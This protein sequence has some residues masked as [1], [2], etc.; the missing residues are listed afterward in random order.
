MAWTPTKAIITPRAIPENLLTYVTDSTRQ[1][2]ALTW[3]G[4]SSLKLL[5]KYNS[6]V[7][8][9]TTPVFPAIAFNDDNDA[10][11]V[12]EDVIDGAY[13]F[14]FEVSIQ[15][16]TP[17]TAISQARTYDK[18]IRSMIVN[19]PAATI[20]A[21]TGYSSISILTIETGFE[22][23]KAHESQANNFLQQFQIRVTMLI[24]AGAFT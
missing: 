15:T 6:H 17:D 5:K 13:S 8:A 3:A 18:A 11:D 24:T 20:G 19:C 7:F 2:D 10:Q 9:N 14:V 21:N 23:L 16:S 4:D 12:S 22:R 1:T